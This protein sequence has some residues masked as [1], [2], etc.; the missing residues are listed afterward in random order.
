V[1]LDHVAHL[2]GLVEVTPAPFNT[3]LFRD[4]DFDVIDGAAVPVIDEQGVGEAQRQQVEDRLFTEIVVDTVDL[5]LFKKLA[6]L[7]VDFTG[8]FQRGAER[9]FHDHARR[10]GIKL[11]FAQPFTDRA[12]G[13][14]RHS[15]IVDGDTVL[16]I[17]HLTQAGEAAGVIDVKITELQASAQGIPQTFI[18]FF[19][20]EGFQ[21]FA[22]DF[23]I[24][25]FIPVGT[26]DANDSGVS[27][28][29]ARLFK[30]IQGRQQFTPRQVALR[31]ENDQVACLGRL[32]YRHVILLS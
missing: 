19:L 26:A 12:K 4:G 5:T 27:V 17:Q 11:R 3:H 31:A 20:H 30:L 24:S 18:N 29:L 14:R 16:L 1:V 25:R 21:R 22:H 2:P 32:R 28:D 9:F 23:G 7:V 13:A 6:D 10:L 8:G 15:E